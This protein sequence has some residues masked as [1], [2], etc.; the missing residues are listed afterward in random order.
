MTTLTPVSTPA[1]IQLLADTANTVWHE[2][3]SS[4]LSPEQIDYMVDKFQSVPALTQQLAEGYQYFLLKQ[5]GQ[6]AGYTGIHGEE[7]RLFLS[8]LYVLNPYR[9][10]GLSSFMLKKIMEVARETG[11]ASIYLTVNKY[12]QNSIEVYEHKGFSTIDSVVTD[13][14]HGFVMD[15]YIMELPLEKA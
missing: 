2:Y 10:Q 9:K 3:F 12:N 4:L 7:T 13:I 11:K 14:G 5:D 1:E 15:D 6:P 8:K